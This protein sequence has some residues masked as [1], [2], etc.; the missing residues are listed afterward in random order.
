M[1]NTDLLDST[2]S[3]AM[4]EVREALQDVRGAAERGRSMVQQLMSFSRISGL[5]LRPTTLLPLVEQ[6]VRMLRRILRDNLTIEVSVA[7]DLPQVMA[8]P[9][10]VEQIILNLATNARDAMPHGGRLEIA[11]RPAKA[12]ELRETEAGH[13]NPA[14]YVAVTVTDTGTGMDDAM[15]QRV[16]EP[17]FTSKPAG[18]GTGLGLS[19]VNGLMHQHGGYVTITS[20][21]GRG[22]TVRLLF[23]VAA[24]TRDEPR[25]SS[26]ATEPATSHGG[27][28]VLV[29]ED[30]D[31]LRRVAQRILERQGYRVLLAEDG[32]A[33]MRLLRKSAPEVNLIFTDMN[34][35]NGGG[36]SLYRQV[37]EEIGPMRFLVA[38]GNAFQEVRDEQVMPA[39]IPFIRKPWTRDELLDAVRKALDAAASG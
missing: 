3:G 18:R 11:A 32:E 39:T 30:E 16:F 15:L 34:M 33:A 26:A 25:I 36:T 20:Q 4:G 28:T 6:V 35:P 2:L 13:G 14:D 9:G 24:P 27:E 31:A 17:F 38:S 1:A 7:E 21:P 8:D 22:T 10:A 29:V 5:D 19:M 23:R 12:D 37:A